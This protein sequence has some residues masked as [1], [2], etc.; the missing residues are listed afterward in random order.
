[1]FTFQTKIE[2]NNRKI[3]A[4]IDSANDSS[5]YLTS[6]AATIAMILDLDQKLSHENKAQDHYKIIQTHG[7]HGELSELNRTIMTKDEASKK[8]DIINACN[9]EL[10]TPKNFTKVKAYALGNI[11][12]HEIKR[13][14]S[15][16]NIELKASIE[17]EG[18][19][20][21]DGNKR[22]E[23]I[24]GG[25]CYQDLSDYLHYDNEGIKNLKIKNMWNFSR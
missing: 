20:F 7:N 19:F 21:M 5:V 18:F 15:L 8:Y 10:W 14:Y 2:Y 3:I 6:P 22:K 24:V 13:H 11:K 23:L 1:M 25:D 9:P 16:G 4:E 12:S 17:G